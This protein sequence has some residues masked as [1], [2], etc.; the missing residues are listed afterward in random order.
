MELD[1]LQA[2][3]AVEQ[4]VAVTHVPVLECQIPR[5][6]SDLTWGFSNAYFGNL[7]LGQQLVARPKVTHV[8]SGHTH[9][10]K[11]EQFTLVDGRSIRAQV[12]GCQMNRP[13]W[14]SLD[15]AATH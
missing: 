11:D 3:A 8:V 6:P 14:I 15:L 9:L 7:T 1:R 2:N 4:I 13:G 5:R 10:A 12:I